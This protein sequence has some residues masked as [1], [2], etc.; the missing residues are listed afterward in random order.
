MNQK[1]TI[2]FTGC[3]QLDFSDSYDAQKVSLAGR[4]VC[5]E[6]KVLTPDTP[7][8][9]QFCKLRGR[10]NHPEACLSL[11]TAVCPDYKEV[12]HSVEVE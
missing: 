12:R 2:E 3:D 9:V 5:W 6:R 10:L 1:A 11:A 7:K 4:K 8:L